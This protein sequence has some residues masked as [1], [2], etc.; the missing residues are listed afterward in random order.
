MNEKPLNVTWENI[1]IENIGIFWLRWKATQTQHT[2]YL[3][4]NKAKIQQ[5]KSIL[6]VLLCFALTK[7]IVTYN[8]A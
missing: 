5:N 7:I 6:Y 8:Y 3:N 2:I 4:I 1:T